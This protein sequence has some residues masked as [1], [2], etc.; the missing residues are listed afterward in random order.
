MVSI[1]ILYNN[2]TILWDIRCICGPSLTETSLCGT[3]LYFAH[4]FQAGLPSPRHAVP[5]L[6]TST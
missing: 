2:I 5:S 1:V 6:C 3:Y 4:R